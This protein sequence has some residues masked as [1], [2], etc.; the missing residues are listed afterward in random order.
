MMRKGLVV[1]DLMY[2]ENPRIV[3]EEMQLYENQI[4]LSLEIHKKYVKLLSE[5]M[6][7]GG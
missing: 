5:Y 3:V 7:E 1:D 2:S 4:K 6:N